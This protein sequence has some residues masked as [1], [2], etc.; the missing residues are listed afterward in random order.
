MFGIDDALIASVGGSLIGGLFSSGGQSSANAANAE[1]AQRQMDFQERM[2]STAYQRATADMKAAGI[3]PMLA[4][5]QGGASSPQGAMA[6]MQNTGAGIGSGIEN[7]VASARSALMLRAQLANVQADTIGKTT[8]NTIK[9]LQLAVNRRAPLRADES[10][11]STYAEWDLQNR[12]QLQ[13]AQ[14]ANLRALA[15]NAQ[16]AK[17]LNEIDAETEGALRRLQLRTGV[18]GLPAAKVKGTALGGALQVAAPA[19]ATAARAASSIPY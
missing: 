7:A 15:D 8:D 3:N 19:A 13:N 18:L 11:P 16:S 14:A 5:Q 1:L 10:G 6:T 4:F 2:S 12:L 9:N 17:R